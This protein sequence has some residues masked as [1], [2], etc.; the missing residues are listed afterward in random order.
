VGEPVLYYHIVVR[1]RE[2]LNL[3][4][5]SIK[6]REALGHYIQIVTFPSH[7]YGVYCDSL[8]DLA[9]AMADTM[10]ILL[11]A[12]NLRRLDTSDYI[13]LASM[14]QLVHT[15]ASSLLDLRI[16]F[17]KPGRELSKTL[18]YVGQLH[19]LE[20]LE[21]HIEHEPDQ[22]TIISG[23]DPS[24][25]PWVL[26]CLRVLCI[27]TANTCHW[28]IAEYLVRCEFLC[29]QEL[30]FVTIVDTIKQMRAIERFFA[31]VPAHKI[32]IRAGSADWAKAL[33]YLR[34]ATR[35]DLVYGSSLVIVGQLPSSIH[36]LHFAIPDDSDRWKEFSPSLN[37]LLKRVH[38]LRDIYLDGSFTWIPKTLST[39]KIRKSWQ[40]D[41]SSDERADLVLYSHKLAERGIN[42]RE[43]HNGLLYL[44]DR[45]P[46]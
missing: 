23:P 37:K 35:L 24:H 22:M 15:R 45:W 44:L 12:P 29:L 9:L 42:L 36:T 40:L 30:K 20:R 31:R 3:L 10:D 18:P 46:C 5:E 28:R 38:G 26:P 14:P 6:Q 19:A 34:A 8:S 13:S 43:D 7:A 2:T 1:C 16:V 17:F 25:P 32:I 33:S 4:A 41:V 21:L 27:T 11:R 39:P